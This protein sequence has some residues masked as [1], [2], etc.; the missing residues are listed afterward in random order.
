MSAAQTGFTGIAL[1][2]MVDAQRYG[3]R[4]GRSVT[5][6]NSE[7]CTA[8]S[9]ALQAKIPGRP[10]QQATMS[11][12]D[13]TVGMVV[14][15]RPPD[16]SLRRS[17]LYRV[18]APRGA[19]TFCG[20]L[21]AN[22]LP[23]NLPDHLGTLRNRRRIFGCYWQTIAACALAIRR[24]RHVC[25]WS[26]ATSARGDDL[27]CVDSGE[28]LFLMRR[29]ASVLSAATRGVRP[30]PAKGPAKPGAVVEPVDEPIAILQG[31]Q[32]AAN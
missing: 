7:L 23:A 20:N 12:Y 22:Q 15:A 13:S 11:R 2:R 31:H 19:P 6:R 21:G 26:S 17:R 4:C 8:H 25:A 16:R 28:A 10:A 3:R 32:C 29:S 1:R 30:V 27:I 5:W 24:Q 18:A 9:T 14:R